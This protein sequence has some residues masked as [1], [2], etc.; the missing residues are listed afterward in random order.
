MSDPFKDGPI[1]VMLGKTRF[2]LQGPTAGGV[3]P[4]VR[5]NDKEATF[6][7]PL[8]LFETYAARRIVQ[9]AMADVGAKMNAIGMLGV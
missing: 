8:A 9:M 7:V 3:C 6:F 2:E 5:K 1:V 4:L